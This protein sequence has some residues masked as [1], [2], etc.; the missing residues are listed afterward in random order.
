MNKNPP[1]DSFYN[2]YYQPTWETRPRDQFKELW[3]NHV[4]DKENQIEWW[5]QYFFGPAKDFQDG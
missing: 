3:E 4:N 2:Q 5:K 1:D